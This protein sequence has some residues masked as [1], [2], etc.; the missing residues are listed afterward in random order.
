MTSRSTKFRRGFTLTEVLV[1]VTVLAGA[2]A[3]VAQ[4]AVWTLGER[5]RTDARL[6]A[7]EAAT[8]VLEEARARPWNDLTAEWASNH[9][10]PENL[11]ARWPD[12]RLSVSVEPEEKRPK[13]KRVTVEIK[14]TETARATWPAVKL[15]ALFAAR[16]AEGKP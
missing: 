8:N 6:E 11:A 5:A 12:C 2:A 16:T 10:L 9:R 14:W 7:V 15:T 4:F 13:I 1:A 3:L